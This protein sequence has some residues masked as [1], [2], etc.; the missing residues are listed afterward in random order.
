MRMAI[1]AITALFAAWAST[2]VSEEARWAL[3][4]G[5]LAGTYASAVIGSR[6]P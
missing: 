5:L 2:W 1:I 6:L 3:A 4:I